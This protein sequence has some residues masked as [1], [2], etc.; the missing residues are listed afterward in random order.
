MVWTESNQRRL[1]NLRNYINRDLEHYDDLKTI[2]ENNY[3]AE[4]YKQLLD[5]FN[6]IEKPSFMTKFMRKR[7]NKPMTNK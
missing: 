6:E 7:A 2:Y 1:Q 4:E 3:L 5:Q